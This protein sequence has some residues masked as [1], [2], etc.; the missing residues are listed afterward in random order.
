[1]SNESI[2]DNSLNGESPSEEPPERPLGSFSGI[3]SAI[4]DQLTPEKRDPDASPT[5]LKILEALVNLID[6]EGGQIAEVGSLVKSIRSS[7]GLATPR[8]GER[9]S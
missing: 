2:N 9:D 5:Q 4:R 1:M 6:R 8:P 7:Y 3:M